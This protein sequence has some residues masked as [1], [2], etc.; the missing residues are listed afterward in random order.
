MPQAVTLAGR[1]G[2]VLTGASGRM[3]GDH[4][5]GGLGALIERG[6]ARQVV[7]SNTAVRYSMRPGDLMAD[8]EDPERMRPE[9]G[10]DQTGR[11][12]WTSF[13]PGGGR[14]T[15]IQAWLWR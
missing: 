11:L 9:F 5:D 2:G 10:A 4:G 12:S 6:V 1:A 15:Q 14:H 7:A 8:G 13:R 3:E